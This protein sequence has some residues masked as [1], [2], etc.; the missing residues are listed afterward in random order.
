MKIVDVI[1]HKLVVP[2][3]PGAVNSPGMERPLTA[4]D[5]IT[6]RMLVDLAQYPKWIIELVAD[7]ATKRSFL[8]KHMIGATAVKTMEGQG[9]ILRNIQDSLAFCPP[10][11]ITTDEIHDMFD[12]VEKGLDE[13]EAHVRKEGARAA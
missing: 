4:P 12:R 2:M 5:P 8:P 1:I 13:M 11:I 7:K 3:K 9:V 6:G 10:L